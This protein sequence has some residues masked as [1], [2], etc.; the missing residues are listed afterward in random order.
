M[1][2]NSN[3][4]LTGL[5]KRQQ[6]TNANKLIFIWVIV[7]AV[8]LSICGVGIQ[9]LF[10]QASFNQKIISA[11]ATTQSTLA[12]NID[13]AKELKKKVDNLL[14]DTNLASVRAN[15]S[16]TTLKVV[17]DALP[18][19]EDSA[20]FA[21]SLQQNV[22][23]KSGVS[24]NELS[25]IGQSGEA[26]VVTGEEVPADEAAVSTTALTTGFNF[27][28]TGGYDQI[29]NMLYDLERTI[30]PVNV[31]VL[32]LTG[33]DSTLRVTASGVTYYLPERTVELGKRTIKP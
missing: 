33:T 24:I 4:Q 13:N 31:T 14:A 1:A 23:S 25:T 15:P 9:F 20:A 18:T 10:R 29:K 16:D 22:L 11:K 7:A 3:K 26:A 28:A 5:K 30:R 27:G 21:S 6:I 32:S 12:S 8:A 2:A 17:L 19:S